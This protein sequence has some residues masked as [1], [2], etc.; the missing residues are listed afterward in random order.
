MMNPAHILFMDCQSTGSS[1]TASSLLELAVNDMSWVIRQE[2]P[3]PNRI[4]KL[5]GISQASID[6][7]SSEA[8][9]FASLS[10]IVNHARRQSD[11]EVFAVAHFAR[12]EAMYLNR[13]WQ[14][15]TGATFPLPLIC[16]HK[17]AKILFPRL[18][19]YGLRAL[20]GWFSLPLEDGKRAAHHVAATKDIWHA[21][22]TEL[23]ARGVKT[24]EQLQSF[25]DQKPQKSSGRREF[26]IPREKRLGLPSKPGVYKYL[27]R[28]GRIL[29]IGKATSLKSRVNSYFT[30]G[31]R[32]DHRKL[33]MLA[34]AVD[35]EVTPM[36]TP[37]CAGLLEYDEIRR[38][39]PPY[40]IAFTG[41]GRNPET[42]LELLTGSEEDF[43]AGDF[44]AII[45][46]NFYGL[47]DPEMLRAGVLLWRKTRG[48]P[49]TSVLTRRTLLNMGVPL[50]KDW[51]AAEK[52][53]RAMDAVAADMEESSEQDESEAN[54][55]EDVLWTA[56]LV[57]ATCDRLIRRATRNFVR[58]R[59]LRRLGGATIKFQ[60]AIKTKQKNLKS[61]AVMFIEP[62]VDTQ[63]F[64]P[65]RVKVL[66]HELRR[67][68]AKG[69]SWQVILPWPMAV[70]FWI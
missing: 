44:K 56:E 41:R 40:N 1:P 47:E 26:L 5:I 21:F 33:E 31:C 27:D 63:G 10:Q 48:V 49:V 29:Y 14:K 36:D 4:L 2:N 20:A 54:D 69:G 66:L 12:F 7:G 17:I 45:R 60:P 3:V 59:W 19:N 38:I 34:Q 28:T 30:G 9:V 13:L 42:A 32:G 55:E 6:C 39:N 51:I 70:P 61:S 52:E 53:R 18:P 58:M 68:Q 46:E 64:D 24:L 43:D 8:E 67:S 35:V 50:L 16:T 57:A 22:G 62:Q 25:C 37:L 11:D 65:R 15:Y 23:E